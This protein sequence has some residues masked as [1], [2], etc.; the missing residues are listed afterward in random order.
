M[1]FFKC[2]IYFLLWDFTWDKTWGPWDQVLKYEAK[3]VPNLLRVLTRELNLQDLNLQFA[4]MERLPF[5]RA[6]V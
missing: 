4:L 3:S 1:F 6:W 2:S 5:L